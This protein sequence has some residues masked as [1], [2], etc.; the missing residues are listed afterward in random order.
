MS[1]VFSIWHLRR[2]DRILPNNRKILNLVDANREF[3]S[4][5]ELGTAEKF[6]VHAEAYEHHVYQP[7][8]DYPTFPQEFAEL[9]P[10][11]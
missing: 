5:K 6:R 9:F 8:D 10:T 1:N 11:R 2:L 7:L 4:P 3:L